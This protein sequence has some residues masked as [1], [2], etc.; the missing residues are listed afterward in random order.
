MKVYSTP[1]KLTFS[2]SIQLEIQHFD[3]VS[4]LTSFEHQNDPIRDAD[5]MQW[6]LKLFKTAMPCYHGGS[7]PSIT[8][9]RCNGGNKSS[10]YLRYIMVEKKLGGKVYKK[11]IME[12][13]SVCFFL[14]PVHIVTT[15][16]GQRIEKEYL[17]NLRQAS[18][19]EGHTQHAGF[20]LS[21]QMRKESGRE[22]TRIF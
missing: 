21:A 5:G 10:S 11:Q 15:L 18:R 22:L 14:W 3:T 4:K 9:L 1:T 17:D 7:S 12:P 16:C 13:I 8:A 6:R 19:R 20:T 2:K